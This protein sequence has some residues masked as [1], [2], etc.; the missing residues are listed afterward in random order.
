M[1]M[2][3]TAELA[4]WWAAGSVVAGGV[5][6]S[7]A[8][9]I[10]SSWSSTEPSALP[11][12]GAG[13]VVLAAGTLSRI[14]AGRSA[15]RVSTVRMIEV[16][17]NAAARIAVVRVSTLPGAARRHE[18]AAA[19]DAERAAFGALHEH[20]RDERDDHHQVNDDDDGFHG[21]NLS[22]E[23]GALYTIG[24]RLASAAPRVTWPRRR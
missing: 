7:G 19:A 4:A 16:A 3:L 15:K 23:F 20:H 8:G 1:G 5:G 21:I 22:V 6:R 24:P 2:P 10:W 17:K 12:T 13:A 11:P 14:E 9:A 18:V